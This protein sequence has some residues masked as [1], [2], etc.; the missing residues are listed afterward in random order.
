M[1]NF[2]IDPLSFWIGFAAA[3]IIW[4]L[5]QNSRPAVKALRNVLSEQV[6]SVRSEISTS[7]EVRYRQDVIRLHQDNHIAAPLF[8]LEEIAVEPR[9]VAPPAPLVPGGDIPPEDVTQVA[10][11]Y[12]PDQTDFGAAFG[13][14]T[15]SFREAMAKGA[16]LLV[17]GQ[18]GSGKTFALSLLAVRVAQRHPWTGELGN[19][20]PVVLHAGELSLSGK[21]GDPLKV[22]YDAINM[23]VSTLVEAQL[24]K[25]LKTIFEDKLALLIIDGLDE[26]PTEAQAPVVRFVQAIQKKYPGNRYILAGSPEDISCQQPLGLVTIPIASWTAKQRRR[27]MHLW[28]TMWQEHIQGQSWTR[29]LPKA[30]DPIFLNNWALNTTLAVSPLIMTLKTWALY[31][32]DILGPKEDQLL[33]AYLYRMTSNINNARP[34]MEQLAMQMTLARTPILARKAAG[35][36][37]SAFEEVES[38]EML[39]D[40]PAR[41]VNSGNNPLLDEEDLYDLLE[42]LEDL[43]LEVEE[44][45]EPLIEARPT[46]AEGDTL[47]PEMDEVKTRQVKR[48]LPELVKA[49]ILVLR[50]DSK[51]SFAHPVVAGYLAGSGLA[52]RGSADQL[53]SQ[54]N[55]SGKSLAEDFFTVFGDAGALVDANTESGQNDSLKQP[56]IAMG[57]WPRLAT[58]RAPWRGQIMRSYAALLQQVDLAIGL[59]ARILASLAFSGEANIGNLF[60]QMIKSSEHTVRWLGALGCG[61]IRDEQSTP[62]LGSLLYDPSIFVSRAA[63]LALVT[64]DTAKSIEMLA[65]ALLEASEEVRRA[66]AEALANH[67][68]E[69]YP[70]L[71][72]GSKV[73][74]LLVRR[75]VVFGLAR[76][77]EPWAVEILEEMQVLDDE[78]F[79]RNASI[80]ALDEIKSLSSTVPNPP[81]ADLHETPWLITFASERGLGVS[82][83]QGAWDM[84]AVALKEGKEE[85][86]L[87]AM[88]IYRSKPNEGRGVVAALYEIMNGQE[89]EMREAAYHTLWHLRAAGVNVSQ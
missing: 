58:K 57:N 55:W 62:S 83:G 22:I 86:R 18:P 31:A 68:E 61:L 69:G 24:P 48:M 74:D 12:M 30:I 47:E 19:L 35:D 70:I 43:D 88:D 46:A 50:P 45:A 40:V 20:I 80:Q 41:P 23:K 32:G 33:E 59:R 64:L 13:V 87:A 75:A 81:V 65:R 10:I 39:S 5:L 54:N 78:W 66:A 6:A 37:V 29:Q 27:F 72:E 79:V 25:F 44:P 73:E 3:S 38:E 89:G 42:G 63:C 2:R 1:L 56:L 14:K 4:W 53:I 67:P 77:A 8:S 52:Q 76:V 26:F 51:I 9:L 17:V 71:K 60:R 49:N 36:F 82:P 7:I 84:L 85:E 34:A 11:P 28:G 15:L 16:N 21:K